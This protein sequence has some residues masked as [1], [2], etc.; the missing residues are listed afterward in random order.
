VFSSRTYLV[1][2]ASSGIGACL[3]DRLLSLNA[4]IV[5]VSRRQVSRPGMGLNWLPCDFSDSV[6]VSALTST[7]ARDYPDIN[8]VILCHG[9]GVFGS[10]EEFSESRIRALLDTNLTSSILVTRACLPNLKRRKSGDLVF[11]GSEAGLKGG[12]KGAV[13]SASKF[14]LRGLAQALRDECASGGVR[15]T[16]VNPGMVDTPFF[17]QLDF[18]P[19]ESEDNVLTADEV[20]QLIVTV[21]SMRPGVVIDEINL[22]PLKT[23]IRTRRGRVVKK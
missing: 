21:L 15:V 4:K 22:S 5:A 17:D 14:A 12:K 6:Q 10:L 20:A 19:G 13:Y 1:S 23:I 11:V 7:L 18:T 9:V 16:M 8:G 3:C 2:G